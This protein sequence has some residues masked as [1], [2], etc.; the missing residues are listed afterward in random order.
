M[1]EILAAQSGQGHHNEPPPVMSRR[2]QI[3][4]FKDGI[5]VVLGESGGVHDLSRKPVT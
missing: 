1:K 4:R 2:E 5:L 3:A